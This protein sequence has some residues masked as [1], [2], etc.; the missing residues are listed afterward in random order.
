MPRATAHLL[1]PSSYLNRPRADKHRD[2]MHNHRR[3]HTRV[4]PMNQADQHQH[5]TRGEGASASFLLTADE[6]AAL[7][8]TSRKAIYAMAERGLLPGV[9]RIGR[10]LLVRRD[11]LVNWLREGRAPSPSEG[12]R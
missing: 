2:A 4:S 11:D 7:L 12:R 3:Q 5:L 8:R 6:V 1:L 9:V 10:R